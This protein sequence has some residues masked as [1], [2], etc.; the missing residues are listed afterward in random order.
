[1]NIE[2]DNAVKEIVNNKSVVKADFD[3]YLNKDKLFYYKS[4]C[5]KKDIE[6]RFFLHIIPKDNS[7]LA[8]GR[9]FKNLDFE[10][11]G[12]IKDY[13]CIV[14]KELPKFD[15]KAISTGQFSTVYDKN[16]KRSFVTHWKSYIDVE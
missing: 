3:I 14:S 10:F 9:N 16:K 4:P 15:I 11:D 7:V 6:H 13:T 5:S 2:F 12:L 1:M 8:K